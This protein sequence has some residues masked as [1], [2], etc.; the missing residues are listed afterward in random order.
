MTKNAVHCAAGQG[1]IC[2]SSMLGE[3]ER[4]NDFED[5]RV[6]DFE[7][8]RVNDFGGMSTFYLEHVDSYDLMTYDFKL[9]RWMRVLSRE[10]A[11]HVGLMV[12]AV[13]NARERQD[14]MHMALR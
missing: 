11:L 5:E 13:A 4:V 7:D 6:N 3:D 9:L 8:E 10:E 12:A 14:G 2:V 1:R